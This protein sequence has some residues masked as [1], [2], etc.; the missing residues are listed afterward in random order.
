MPTKKMSAEEAEDLLETA[1]SFV[2][3]IE[4]VIEKFRC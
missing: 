4:E 3:R 2:D 1:R